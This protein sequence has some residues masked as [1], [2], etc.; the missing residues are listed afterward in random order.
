M[1][2]S[3]GTQRI[4]YKDTGKFS[5]IITDYVAGSVPRELYKH[6]VSLQGIEQAIH[7]RNI[8]ATDRKL[9]V[10][11]LQQQYASLHGCD[12]VN[13]NISELGNVNT[14]T[15]C[16]AHQPNIFTG[17]LYFIYKIIHVI[18]LA[19]QLNKELSQS[20][21]VPVFYM[22]SE[23][24]D[25]DELGHVFL[26]GEKYEWKTTQTGSVGRMLVDSELL[27]LIELIGGQINVLPHGEQIIDTIKNCYTKGTTIEAATFK[28][29]HSLFGD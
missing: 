5:K 23:D 24:A 11:Q 8:F 20:K 19:D 28:L 16:T 13:Q 9:L 3:Q 7:E 27:T 6:E 12:K 17:H 21:F 2:H 4:E 22:G 15:I 10:E 14:Y 29:I 25:L 18:K 1:P 26:F